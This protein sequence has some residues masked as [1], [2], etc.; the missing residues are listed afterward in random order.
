MSIGN[1]LE[2]CLNGYT[3]ENFNDKFLASAD[4]ISKCLNCPMLS[5]HSAVDGVYS[6]AYIEEILS[7]NNKEENVYEN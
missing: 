3:V 1:K 7:A 4:D 5:P 2:G 6:C